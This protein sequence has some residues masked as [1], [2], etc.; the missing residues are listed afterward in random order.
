MVLLKS[1]PKRN[2]NRW[3]RFNFILLFILGS[4]VHIRSFIHI[5]KKTKC[6]E[7]TDESRLYD[8]M[9]YDGR[10]HVPWPWQTQKLSHCSNSTA[11]TLSHS[12]YPQLPLPT[13]KWELGVL[14]IP[15]NIL[16]NSKEGHEREP[17]FIQSNIQNNLNFFPG[18]NLISD[19][20]TS[21][22]QKLKQVD[23]YNTSEIETWFTSKAIGVYKSDVCRMAQLYLHGGI[24]LDNDLEL[25]SPA[26]LEDLE[27]GFDVVS[28]ISLT[29]KEIFQA[30]LGAPP[31]H[32]LIHRAM[33][34]SVE[35]ILKKRKLTYDWMGTGAVQMAIEEVYEQQQDHPLD[36]KMLQC[37]GVHLLH[38]IGL[39]SNHPEM[40]NRSTRNACNIAVVDND[41]KMYAF[42][43][44]KEFSTTNKPCHFK[45]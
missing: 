38:E 25:M 27:S 32:P 12:L 21:C 35:I 5:C 24:Y 23:V 20:D 40:T 33:E 37:L 28:A 1:K 26:I 18:W 17:D 4:L 29:K 6:S 43:R 45:G 9:N 30:I 22:L 8:G 3:I 7:V 31:G 10:G 36:P 42:S 15:S 39:P 13:P 44:V 14:R 2:T 11:Q 16:I 19:D 34:L 41:D